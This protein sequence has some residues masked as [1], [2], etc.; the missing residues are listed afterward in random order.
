MSR[1]VR[2]Q[3]LLTTIFATGA[4][5]L[6]ACG[7]GTGSS[8]SESPTTAGATSAA[9]SEAAASGSAEALVV[10]SGRSESLVGPLLEQFTE[11]TGIATEVR[12]GDSAEL[13]A[14][15]VEEGDQSPADVFWSQDAGALG[16][17]S[18][19]G[20]LGPIPANA[21]SQVPPQYAA[22]DGTWVGVTGRSRVI[23]YDSEQVPE[24][25]VPTSVFDL[26]DPK[27]AGKVGIAPT[28]AS[29]Q[30]F[31]TAMRLTEGDD[32]TQAWLQGLVDNDVQTYEK[33]GLILDAV[34][35]GQISLGLIN[36]YYWFEKAAEVGE[37]AMRAQI[38]FSAPGDPGALVN[39]AGVGI[40][41]TGA[42]EQA[43]EFVTYLLTPDAQNYFATE[44]FEY[45]L[46]AGVDTADG[47]PAL[48]E[49]QGPPVPLE[50]L[51]ELPATQQMLADVGL[52]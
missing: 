37:D 14:Q 20:L 50:K 6:A 25:E 33:N 47:L 52:I 12:Y 17:V 3:T 48:A 24:A 23:A 51:E 9:A 22:E 45:P 29:F 41:T 35:S 31:V 18:S 5:A 16:A 39:V 38:A 49:L 8:A 15:L 42:G 30:S 32:A 28:N 34:N 27:W 4:L 44:T 13:A 7:G 46:V 1:S 19:A 43:D 40:L 21:L 11:D 10:Y 2:R 26:T 36:H